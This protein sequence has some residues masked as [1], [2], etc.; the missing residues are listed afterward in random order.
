MPPKL[1]KLQEAMVKMPV[2]LIADGTVIAV[3]PS[4]GSAASMPAFALASKGFVV[5]SGRIVLPLKTNNTVW[6]EDLGKTKMP[7]H[8]RLFILQQELR[9]IVTRP[10]VLAIESLPPFM[11]AA[12]GDFRN[13]GTVNLHQSAGCIMSAW[14]IPWVLPVAIRSHQVLMQKLTDGKY[15]KSDE[16]DALSILVCLFHTAGVMLKNEHE[17]IHKVC[18]A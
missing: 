12:G 3:D 2:A 17:V 15:V 16:N 13:Q 4:S 1:T 14:A 10:D 9:R 18:E 5:N 8:L 7:L 6:E 11:S